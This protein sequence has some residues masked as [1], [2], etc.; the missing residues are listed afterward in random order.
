MKR[1]SILFILFILF[2][3]VSCD[4]PNYNV[5][6]T[7][8]NTNSV[9]QNETA[10]KTKYY[11]LS[12]ESG[13]YHYI[14][15]N[16]MGNVVE[17]GSNFRMPKISLIDETYVKFT[18]QTGTGLSTQ[19]GYYYD[20]HQDKKSE[21]FTCIYDEYNEL[22]AYGG[23]N[24]VIVQNIFDENIYYKEYSSFKQPF[25]DVVEPIVNAEFSDDGKYI[26]I[27]YLSGS[28]YEKITESIEI[29]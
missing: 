13:A 18:L 6:T 22:T 26:L 27:T 3:F 15:Y 17:E 12:Y 24:K 19:W 4:Y 21:I 20:V 28:N 5:S 29:G 14:I 10:L 11:N 16:D 2:C 23:K 8:T 7:T 9:C 25:S 1:V